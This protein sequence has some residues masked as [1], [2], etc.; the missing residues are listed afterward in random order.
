MIIA[1]SALISNKREWN[2]CFMKNAPM[3]LDKSNI[4]N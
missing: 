3:T 4:L 1:N 2:N